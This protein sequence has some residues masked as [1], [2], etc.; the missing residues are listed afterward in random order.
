[1]PVKFWKKIVRFLFFLSYLT[2]LLYL[3][4]A[5][6]DSR[7]SRGWI[8]TDIFKGTDKSVTTFILIGQILKILFA[9]AS[10][11]R[12]GIGICLW[13]CFQK[14]LILFYKILS[15]F[16]SRRGMCHYSI[17][18]IGSETVGIMGQITVIW[19]A[20]IVGYLKKIGSFLRHFSNVLI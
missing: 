10:V 9:L 19:F 2:I 14:G 8:Q 3:K 20:Y 1:M 18:P 17:L 12:G 4:A 15:F 6:K 13:L 11:L 5:F 7:H 16:N